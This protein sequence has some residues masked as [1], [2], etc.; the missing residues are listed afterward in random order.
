M[1]TLAAINA[2]E[3]LSYSQ[4][5]HGVGLL[6]IDRPPVN[7]LGRQLVSDLTAASAALNGDRSVR[8]LVLAAGGR[9]FC[10]GADLKERQ[11]MNQEEVRVFVRSLAASFQQL[12][13]LPFP[14]VAAI[15]GTAAGGG[16]ELALACDFRVLDQSGRIGLPETTLGIV[17]G[18]GGTQRLPRLIGTARAK[19]W[20]FTGRLYS[21]DEALADGVVDAAVPTDQVRP[22]ALDMMAEM[23]RSAPLALKAAKAAVDEAFDGSMKDGLEREWRAYESILDT[24]DRLEALA[25]FREKRKPVFKGH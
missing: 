11:S 7:A 3:T 9:T 15:H 14:T 21:A 5:E 2:M 18:A 22:T 1:T 24:E 10:A 16:C 12:A 20:I 6:V 8:A 4:D 13:E 17:P 23:A 19:K 25:A